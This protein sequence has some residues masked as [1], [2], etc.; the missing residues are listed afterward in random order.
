MSKILTPLNKVKQFSLLLNSES[1]LC[2]CS[3]IPVEGDLICGI[4]RNFWISELFASCVHINI[5]PKMFSF[6]HQSQYSYYLGALLILFLT[7][8]PF[9]CTR[10]LVG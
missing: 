1:L 6:R 3:V 9:Q 5:S 7:H 2:W 4:S 8:I 10:L